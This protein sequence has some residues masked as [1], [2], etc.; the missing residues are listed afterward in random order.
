[1]IDI[2]YKSYRKDFKWLYYS[3]KSIRKFVTNYNQIIIVIPKEDKDILDY[4][5][6]EGLKYKV[7]TV[8]EY[9]N[10]YLYQQWIKMSAYKYCDSEYI[11]FCDSDC[12]FDKK[13]DLSDYVNK[14]PEILYTDYSKVGD[15]ICWKEPTEKFIGKSIEYEFM[16]RNFLIYLKNTLVDIHKTYPNLESIIVDSEAFS[17]FNAIGAWIY[18]NESDKYQLINTDFAE[19]LSSFGKQFW[20][21]SDLNDDDLEQIKTILNKDENN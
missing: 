9:G 3:I 12:I 2:F 18:F 7:F 11:L 20:S 10:G 1:M 14:K 19:N 15:A 13:I 17:E 6:L 5:I 8:D 16:R 21:W 4:S